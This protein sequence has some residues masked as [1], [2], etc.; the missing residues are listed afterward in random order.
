MRKITLFTIFLALCLL[1]GTPPV[2][3]AGAA[4]PADEAVNERLTLPYALQGVDNIDAWLKSFRAL[5]VLTADRITPDERREVGNLAADMQTI[6]FHN[7]VKAVEGTLL[8]QECDLRRL[9]YELARER[10]AAGK[11]GKAEVADKEQKYQEAG[12]ALQD[13]LAKFRIAD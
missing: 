12:K 13:F 1:T 9:E 5:T 8:R 11:V 6:G 10:Q 7:W 2:Q 4:Q 3:A